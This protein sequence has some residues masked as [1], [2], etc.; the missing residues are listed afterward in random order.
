MFI[1]ATDKEVLMMGKLAI[2]ASVPVGIGVLHHDPNLKIDDVQLTLKSDF[3][4]GL[5]IDYYQGRMVKFRCWK[6][7]GGFEFPDTISHEYESWK[8]TYPDYTALFQAAQK[9]D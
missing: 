2:L 7:E 3:N 5:F 4:P 6:K 8:R 9:C 1:A